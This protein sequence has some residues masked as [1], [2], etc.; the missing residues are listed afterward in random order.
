VSQNKQGDA[1]VDAI[2]LWLSAPLQSCHRQARS[3]AGAETANV[4]CANELKAEDTLHEIQRR[5][6]IDTNANRCGISV[7]VVAI[8]F[9]PKPI[10]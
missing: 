7:L 9:K 2:H 4:F 5:R 10:S 6:N 1:S 8:V 3:A